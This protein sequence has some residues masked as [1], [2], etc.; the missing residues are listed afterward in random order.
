MLLTESHIHRDT[1]VREGHMS[2]E[3]EGSPNGR[4]QTGSDI[5][6]AGVGPEA[7]ATPCRLGA[8]DGNKEG[9]ESWAFS[10]KTSLHFLWK[11]HWFEGRKNLGNLVFPQQSSHGV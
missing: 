10:C 11:T 8:W 2:G 4:E 6:G 3:S 1:E 5:T 7:E 9:S